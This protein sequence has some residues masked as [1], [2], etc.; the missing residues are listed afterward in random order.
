MAE[1]ESTESTFKPKF[2]KPATRPKSVT[3]LAPG[4]IAFRSNTTGFHLPTQS[5]AEVSEPEKTGG[6]RKEHIKM[7]KVKIP[8]GTPIRFGP[9]GE[10][11]EVDFT[12]TME[13]EAVL[14]GNAN[15]RDGTLNWVCQFES[16]EALRGKRGWV[17]TYLTG[18]NKKPGKTG[19]TQTFDPKRIVF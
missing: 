3:H 13:G 7:Q 16:P 14:L 18:K 8:A 2:G 5:H 10:G 4:Q 1:L 11:T 17:S 9:F 19:L 6:P 15:Q 12:T